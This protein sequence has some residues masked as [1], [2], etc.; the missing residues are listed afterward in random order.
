[1]QERERV[2][3]MQKN[4]SRLSTLVNFFSQ[5]HSAFFLSSSSS[6]SL[7]SLAE[8]FRLLFLSSFF[9]MRVFVCAPAAEFS[10]YGFCLCSSPKCW[11]QR[12]PTLF[13]EK[14]HRMKIYFEWNQRSANYTRYTDANKC[15]RAIFIHTHT[16]FLSLLCFQHCTCKWF[17]FSLFFWLEF[18]SAFL[19]SFIFF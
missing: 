11:S 17:S 16:L 3:Y 2:L 7:V 5:F 19:Y 9:S 4:M 8:F 14:I 6:P 15:S 10:L 1:M 12:K 13:L 18:V